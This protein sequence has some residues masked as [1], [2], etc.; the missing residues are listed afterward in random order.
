MNVVISF[1]SQQPKESVH[2]NG[3]RMENDSDEEE[4]EEEDETEDDEEVSTEDGAKDESRTASVS[5][6][7]Y[8]INALDNPLICE[9][10]KNVVIR[11]SHLDHFYFVSRLLRMNRSLRSHRKVKRKVTNQTW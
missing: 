8:F 11:S 10:M 3:E 1:A 7:N 5:R 2:M 9:P 6:V 4:S